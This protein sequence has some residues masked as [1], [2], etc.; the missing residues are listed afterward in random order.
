MK[1]KARSLLAGR[2][3]AM[4]SALLSTLLLASCGGKVG[5]T[6]TEDYDAPQQQ[7]TTEEVIIECTTTTTVVSTTYQPTTATATTATVT[8]TNTTATTL[9][10]TKECPQIVTTT[11][12]IPPQTIIVTETEPYVEPVT[13]LISMGEFEATWYTAVDMGYTSAPY[14]SSGRTL[15]SG[16][17]IASNYFQQGTILQI[18]GGGLDGTYRVDDTGGMANNVIDFYYWDRSGVPSSFLNAGRVPITVYIVE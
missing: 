4:A 2:Q 8:T 14:G 17:S 7:T 18:E 3:I 13:P 15:V 11:T 9:T 1:I 10:Y 16:Y 12:A 6:D 5:R